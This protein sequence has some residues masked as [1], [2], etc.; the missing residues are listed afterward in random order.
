MLREKST[1]ILRAHKLLDICLTAAA[2]IAAYF[3]KRE[4]LPEPLRGL[5]TAPNYYIVLLVVIIIWF[6]TF[7]VLGLYA[8]FRQQALGQVI[9]NMVK[10]VSLSMLVLF[11]FM[12]ILKVKDVSRVMIGIFYLLN[13]GLLALSKGIAY[14]M[15]QH[16][17][18]QGFNFRSVLIVG[19]KERARDTIDTIGDSLKAG[20][21]ILGCLDVDGTPVG[22]SVKNGV[23]VIGMIEQLK[24][25]LTDNV[26]DELIFAIPLRMIPEA[27][28]YITVAEYMGISVRIIPDWQLH[29]LM[30]RPGLAKIEFEEFLGLPTMT[31]KTTPPNQGELLIKTV[32]DYLFAF[33]VLV[34]LLPVFL[35]ISLLIKLSSTGPVFFKQERMGL[36]GRRLGVS[37]KTVNHQGRI[38]IINYLFRIFKLIKN[39]DPNPM[40]LPFQANTERPITFT[41]DTNIL[42]GTDYTDNFEIRENIQ[43]NWSG[44]RST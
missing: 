25:I 40:F 42:A 33:S 23:K 19:S 17:R 28:K 37:V 3:I 36:N 5:T 43:N 24:E 16:Y 41:E 26:V 13:I 2:F 12:Y 10:A 30:Y 7:D 29:Y 8:S 14:K 22:Q 6:L 4:L 1:L 21:K 18:S 38:L 20:F 9:G 11:L 35:A 44:H 32:F 39:L 31:L 27:E 34:I 15:L